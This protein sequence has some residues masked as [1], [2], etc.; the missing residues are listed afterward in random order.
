MKIRS[1]GTDGNPYE[2][3]SQL[4][5]TEE[6]KAAYLAKAPYAANR[7]TT[8]RRADRDTSD[9]RTDRNADC[10]IGQT[11]IRAPPGSGFLIAVSALRGLIWVTVR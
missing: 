5:F 2:F 8:H 7:H 6:F 11:G 9:G 1:T 10:L 4:Y 3:T